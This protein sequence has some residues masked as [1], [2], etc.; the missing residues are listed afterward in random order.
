MKRYKEAA[1]GEKGDP[2]GN[3]ISGGIFPVAGV[4]GAVDGGV[5]WMG[6]GGR[7]RPD[8]SQR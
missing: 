1:W 8:S 4:G 5:G 7:E 3:K 6:V 2:R